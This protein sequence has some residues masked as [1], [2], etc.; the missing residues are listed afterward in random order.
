MQALFDV[1]QELKCDNAGLTMMMARMQCAL[2]RD[3]KFVDKC[4]ALKVI[5]AY[6]LHVDPRVKKAT[7]KKFAYEERKD[8]FIYDYMR[9]PGWVRN[10][11][12]L[13]ELAPYEPSPLVVPVR[14]RPLAMSCVARLTR[15]YE[16]RQEEADRI[17]ADCYAIPPMAFRNAE[18]DEPELEKG[19]LLHPDDPPSKYRA[20]AVSIGHRAQP[21]PTPSMASTAVASAA[22]SEGGSSSSTMPM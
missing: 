9:K 15:M 7:R 1:V 3:N 13:L 16:V 4:A 21:Y 5:D 17:F 2:H 11:N 18:D 10:A 22:A 20:N 19:L 12:R 8:T 6:D 14:R